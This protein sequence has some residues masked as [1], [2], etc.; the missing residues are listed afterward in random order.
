MKKK[1]LEKHDLVKI[2]SVMLIVVFVLSWFIPSGTF[3][4]DGTII[5]GDMW[6]GL[7]IVHIFYALVFALQNYSIQIA[8]LLFLGIFYGIASKTEMYK[9]F[10]S[11]LAH[12]GKGKEIGFALVS[13]L[14]IVLLTSILNNTM[15]V[16][17]FVPLIFTVLRK[18]GF[19]KISTFAM[20]FGSIL[21]GTLGATIGTDGFV[22]FVEYIA[23]AGAEVSL[24]TE[25]VVRI[26]IL[27][28]AFVLFHF[29][30]VIYMKKNL[31]FK[32]NEE[33]ND[34][35]FAVEE[36]KGKKTRTWPFILCLVILVIFAILGFT[37]FE[38]AFDL[39]I[40]D[41]FHQWLTNIKIGD[42]AIFQAILGQPLDNLQ[43]ELVPAFG[44]WY[45]FTYLIILAL[46][47]LFIAIV[48]KMKFNEII[49]NA[50]EG[51]KKVARPILF[52][53]L[54]YM[55]FV[56]L[57]WVP[58]IPTIIHAI[59]G[60]TTGFNPFVASLQALV[61][62]FF[63]SDFAFL[64]FSVNYYLATFTGTELNIMFLIYTTIYGLVQ[65]IT[66]V[67]VFLIFGL[68]YSNVLYKNWFKYIWKFLVGLL[69][70]LLV[71]F[72]L[73]TYL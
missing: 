49:T 20:T 26:G 29:F 17:V 46:V 62:G 11:K 63:N 43:Y 40:F 34:D 70:C 31:D 64:G 30:N 7:G 19:D 23:Y 45:L 41:D 36:P 24:T 32:K 9:T 8:F 73:L 53:V 42:I 14:L 5:M 69:I 68:A 18:M 57:Y 66:P 51:M 56:F 3:D 55:V 39:T 33:V 52:L 12:F 71:I 10:V 35:V 4:T 2:I 61:G 38:G 65:F 21:I 1:F 13:S 50:W 16:L 54:S 58:Y 67:S 48:S 37:S 15:V 25:I 22:N 72:T 6:Q 60:I 44:T 47:T 27:I 59:G 28:L